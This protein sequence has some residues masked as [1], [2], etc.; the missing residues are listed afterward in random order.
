MM[1]IQEPNVSA[2]ITM[3][4]YS[5]TDAIQYIRIT[6]KKIVNEVDMIYLF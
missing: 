5:F 1:Q 3:L 6:I 4:D 2:Y